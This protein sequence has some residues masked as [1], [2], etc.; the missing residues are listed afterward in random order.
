MT[1][2]HAELMRG[3]SRRA[4]SAARGSDQE[5]AQPDGSARCTASLLRPRSR[6]PCGRSELPE[7]QLVVQCPAQPGVVI[8]LD[9]RFP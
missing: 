2:I 3:R 9:L 6:R 8:E 4:L 5:R 7:V 1:A